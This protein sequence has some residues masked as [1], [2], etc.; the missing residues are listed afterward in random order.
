MLEEYESLKDEYFYCLRNRTGEASDQKRANFSVFKDVASK[1]WE[2]L[3]SMDELLKMTDYTA[4]LDDCLRSIA[5]RRKRAQIFKENQAALTSAED[6]RF[7]IER[8]RQ[9]NLGLDDAT[10][11]AWRLKDFKWY[12][13]YAQTLKK[14]LQQVVNNNAPEY[15]EQL[16]RHLIQWRDARRPAV[17]PLVYARTVFDSL[18]TITREVMYRIVSTMGYGALF[19][20]FF[21]LNAVMYEIF[22]CITKL[23]QA[24]DEEKYTGSSTIE[25]RYQSGAL[26]FLKPTITRLYKKA[27]L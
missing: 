24:L 15:L 14:S 21:W 6:L 23:D 10:V 12:S 8:N 13:T 1:L 17:S 16:Y 22:S 7:I 5:E 18:T 11:E 20:K 3:D 25:E 2:I 9:R 19:W 4:T 26:R 27:D